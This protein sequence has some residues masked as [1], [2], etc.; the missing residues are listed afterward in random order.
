MKLPNKTVIAVIDDDSGRI[1]FK[2]KDDD[3]QEVV[4]LPGWLKRLIAKARS[5]SYERGRA[6]ARDEVRRAIGFR[7]RF[8]L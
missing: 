4:K 5:V 1:I 6:E 2:R 7:G 8:P 3:K